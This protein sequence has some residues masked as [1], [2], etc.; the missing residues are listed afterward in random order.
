MVQ[1]SLHLIYTHTQI[2]WIFYF[3]SKQQYCPLTKQRPTGALIRRSQSS[4]SASHPVTVLPAL[5][6]SHVSFSKHKM[7]QSLSQKRKMEVFLFTFVSN[8]ILLLFPVS[9]KKM[10]IFFSFIHNTNKKS[11]DLMTFFFSK[12]PSKCHKTWVNK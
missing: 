11:G 7:F 4:S 3:C 8:T 10:F 12:S 1:S 2:G 5:L 9:E 6:P